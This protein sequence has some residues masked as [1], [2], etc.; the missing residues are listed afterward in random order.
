AHE[1]S[2][3]QKTSPI[4]GKASWLK[5]HIEHFDILDVGLL[6]LPHPLRADIQGGIHSIGTDPMVALTFSEAS[7]TYHYSMEHLNSAYR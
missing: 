1:E 4:G 5:Y 3:T 6:T 7:L 2:P